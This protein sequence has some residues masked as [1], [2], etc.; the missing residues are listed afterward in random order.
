MRRLVTA[1]AAAALLAGPAALA[2][3]S[4][5][6][7]PQPRLIAALVVWACVLGLALTGPVRLPATRAGQ[8]ALGGLTAMLAWS[9]LSLAWAP[10][11]GPALVSVQRLSL[12]LGA[13]FLALQVL[14]DPRLRHAVEP[15]LLGGIALVIGYGLLGRLLPGLVELARSESAGGRLEQPITYW[16]SEGLLAA[17]GV[18]LAARVA[19]D[20]RRRLL[21]RAA[22]AAAAPALGAAVY[23][24]FSRGA[25]T[26][27]ALGLIVLVA[28]APQR[29]QLRAAGFV[30]AGGLAAGAVAAA[31][32]GVASLEG[33]L[34]DRE[35]E[36]LIAFAALAALGALTA[37]ATLRRPGR[38]DATAPA[39]AP[40]LRPAA[41]VAAILVAIGLVVGGLGERPSE[42]ELA[43]GAEAGR[44]TTV[45]SNRY[46]YWRA[47]LAA[48]AREPL[49]GLGAGGFRVEWLRERDIAES[50]KDVH[51]LE[52]EMLAELGLPGF[53]A[54]AALLAGVALA[55]RDVLRA[56][57]AAVAGTSA[58]LAAW[59]LHAS[60]DWDW[61]FPAVTLPAIVLAG[62]LLAAR[63]TAPRA[64]TARRADPAPSPAPSPDASEPDPARS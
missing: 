53:L 15:A 48:F 60:I 39:W 47:G 9:A 20:L 2:F 49:T 28:F 27:V 34:G 30:L 61:Q 3:F 1:V 40:R 55:A 21:L 41:A 35:G 24:S 50:V 36:G 31:L 38:D 10:L 5:G 64:P 37:W 25:L 42:A 19:G 33:S 7:F 13:L 63:E 62:A 32:P 22:A 4:G 56:D 52:L 26:S 57:P 18:V 44:L 12:Y 23:I 43:R 16:N 45:S 17:V 51:S 46:D 11:A 8:L 14:R 59:L 58:A 6:Y 29:A 54:F